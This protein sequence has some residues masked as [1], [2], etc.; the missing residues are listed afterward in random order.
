MSRR[1]E[2]KLQAMMSYP[3]FDACG[4][5][6]PENVSKAPGWKFAVEQFTSRKWRN[7]RLMARNAIFDRV[8]TKDWNRAQAWNSVIDELRPN[9]DLLVDELTR[10]PVIP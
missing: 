8:Q 6:L 1:F 7:C 4:K 2:S 5:P 9:V 10:M 3:F